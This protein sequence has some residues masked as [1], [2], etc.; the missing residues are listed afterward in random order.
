MYNINEVDAVCKK[1]SLVT[2]DVI[3]V[4]DGN[5]IQVGAV[6]NNISILIDWSNPRDKLRSQ[7]GKTEKHSLFYP[8]LFVSDSFSS[9]KTD[10][11][12]SLNKVDGIYNECDANDILGSLDN[13]IAA[14]QNAGPS[15]VVPGKWNPFDVF[16]VYTETSSVIDKVSAYFVD[17]HPFDRHRITNKV[18]GDP[19]ANSEKRMKVNHNTVLADRT[20]EIFP[21]R[22]VYD[23]IW[24]PVPSAGFYDLTPFENVS[25]DFPWGIHVERR[26]RKQRVFMTCPTEEQMVMMKLAIG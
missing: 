25:W 18:L 22:Q 8:D 5:M 19:W 9:V 13:I 11:L 26:L 17:F 14:I 23:V 2:E 21:C 1:L 3:S 15:S 20:F 10:Y 12:S 24:K 16:V 6:V 7:L 4:R